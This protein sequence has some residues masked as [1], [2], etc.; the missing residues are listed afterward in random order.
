M[1]FD[2]P[3]YEQLPPF[4]MIF[5]VF[6][7]ALLGSFFNVLSLRWPDKIIHENDTQA[8]YWLKLRGHRVRDVSSP[9]LPLLAG[10][11]HCPDCKKTI[12]LYLN[13]PIISWILLRGKSL[14]CKKPIAI[15]Y[16]AWELVGALVFS[17]VLYVVGPTTYGLVIGAAIMWML[18][19]SQLDFKV[20][21][22]PDGAMK[23]LAVM[24]ALLCT[25][26]SSHGLE[27]AFINF[28]IAISVLGIPILLFQW[29]TN[30]VGT[31][32]ADIYLVG[33]SYALLG[34]AFMKSVMLMFLL[35]AITAVLINKFKFERGLFLKL[36][37]KKAI[38]AAPAICLATIITYF[39]TLTA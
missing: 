24:I 37:D 20:G 3:L 27:L 21:L 4:F 22:I 32:S 7:G 33:M 1:L 11:S 2:I 17:S 12:P 29:L 9:P 38:P 36:V 26:P 10:R 8:S 15:K 30:K 14:C 25:H 35:F 34:S 16:I 39:L 31:G 13:I 23:V 28:M 19:I 5:F 6:L 18:L